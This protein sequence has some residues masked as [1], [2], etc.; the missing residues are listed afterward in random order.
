M[1]TELQTA[2]V[3]WLAKKINRRRAKRY[4]RDHGY[5]GTSA[6]VEECLWTAE[7][8]PAEVLAEAEKEVDAAEAKRK[9]AKE[10]ATQQSA[11][12]TAWREAGRKAAVIVA[13]AAADWRKVAYLLC[14]E[15]FSSPDCWTER[16]ADAVDRWMG[17][18]DADAIGDLLADQAAQPYGIDAPDTLDEALET[19][20]ACF[21]QAFWN[22]AEQSAFER[23]KNEAKRGGRYAVMG[24]Y[25][26]D[27]KTVRDDLFEF[28]DEEI[29]RDFLTLNGDEG[30]SCMYHV[31]L[32]REKDD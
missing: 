30:G 16:Y 2:K 3:F 29:A 27:M 23:C 24:V 9:A 19:L 14:D 22:A 13:A 6:S 4:L 8:L 17:G 5:A 15:S 25:R 20:L 32:D 28:E 12:A 21:K 7:K 31:L 18:Q 26:G 10:R 11:D 1:L